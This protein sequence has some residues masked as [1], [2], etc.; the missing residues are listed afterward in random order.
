MDATHR[1]TE[2]LGSENWTVEDARTLY[3]IE[4]WGGGFFELADSGHVQVRPTR[5]S[6]AIDL[7]VL[8][9]ELQERGIQLPILLRFS[10]ILE[11]RLVEIHDAFGQAIDEY[12]YASSYQGV[13]PIKVNEQRQVIG[14]ILAAGQDR[15]FGL[16][17]GSKPEL[18][19]ALGLL[20]DRDALMICNGYKDEEYIEL[21]LLGRQI[22]LNVVLVVEKFS[23][24]PLIL[25]V[26]DRLGVDPRLGL[27]VRLGSRGA[28]RWEESGGDR[29]KF[30]LGSVATMRAVNL[31]REKG[32]LDRLQLL[33][34][35]LGSQIC[36]VAS[37]RSAVREA[38]RYYVELA[39]LGARLGYF[40]V[41]GGLAVDYDGSRTAL[42]SSANYS[43][44]EYANT[45]VW[46][47]MGATKAAEVDPPI[48][49]SESGRALTAHHSVLVTNVLG[50]TEVP[51]EPLGSGD[52]SD[53]VPQLQELGSVYRSLDASNFQESYHDVREART[54]LFEMFKLGMINL[55]WWG[56]AESYVWASLHRIW[57]LTRELDQVPDELA[58]LEFELSDIYFVNLSV[59]QSLPDSW[60][61]DHV[62]PILPIHRLDEAP[63]RRAV[64]ADITCDSDGK[65]D[66]F[67]DRAGVRRTL[68]LRSLREDE[69]YLLG[70][71]L[72]GAYQEILG[73]LHNL[74]GD[75]NAVHVSWDAAAGT[76]RIDH[77]EDGDT[78]TEVLAYVQ[79]SR[80]ELV[81][82]LRRKVEAA[83]REQRLSID[84]AR[85]VVDFYR[86][87]FEG[88]TYI[89]G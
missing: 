19:S 50:V 80:E 52:L 27:R 25:S 60:A 61:I 3:G 38:A 62:F 65:I 33:H 47:L 72:V 76:Y 54:Q 11:Q 41:G 66:R 17:V 15:R 63:D 82:S 43:V 37:L 88:Y 57:D 2:S 21:A 75:N 34:Y 56:I 53:A 69:P 4:D 79:Q 1:T 36:S 6:A 13:Y 30:G 9:D 7:K 12:G 84:K 74:F 29:S 70:F 71:F 31:L 20:D 58:P 10:D 40:D 42:E 87:G 59:F 86:Q 8:V 18:L 22:G 5:D 73:D 83:V 49:V 28:G 35:H 55:E 24:L 23:E 39:G 26:A 16:E 51:A 78:V 46:E 77:V 32:K 64:L 44:Q 85:Y 48:L 68:P 45:V 89:E 67:V 14:S 81:G